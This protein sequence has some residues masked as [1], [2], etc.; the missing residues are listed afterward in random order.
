MEVIARIVHRVKV[1]RMLVGRSQEAA[2][3]GRGKGPA[4][5]RAKISARRGLT[6]LSTSSRA[7]FEPGVRVAWSRVPGNANVGFG[8][9]FGRGHTH[10][11]APIRRGL[12]PR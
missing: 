5:G 1:E 2:R 11:A 3:P 9:I 8:M 10:G 4:Y 12:I 6:I 7:G